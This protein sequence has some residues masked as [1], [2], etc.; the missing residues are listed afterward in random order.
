MLKLTLGE[1]ARLA[2]SRKRVPNQRRLYDTRLLQR[3]FAQP[4]SPIHD[5]R[6]RTRTI[7]T[8]KAVFPIPTAPRLVFS[9]RNGSA[10]RCGR[11][12]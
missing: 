3:L 5:Q 2:A 12:G 11:R 1:L 8:E 6:T 10:P 4:P 9:I 7:P